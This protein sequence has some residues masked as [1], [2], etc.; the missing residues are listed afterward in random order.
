MIRAITNRSLLALTGLAA[1]TAGLWLIAA[2]YNSSLLPT[3][4]A[5]YTAASDTGHLVGPATRRHLLS[6][7]HG[8]S[9]PAALLALLVLALLWLVWQ[10]GGLATRE[11]RLRAAQVDARAL[12][13]QVAAD[14]ETVDGVAAARARFVADGPPRLHLALRTAPGAEPAHVLDELRHHLLPR[15]AAVCTGTPPRVEVR[16]NGIRA[17]RRE[18]SR[19]R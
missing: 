12:A 15:I 11:L 18:I 4:A 14:A 8:W 2:H 7:V 10:R 16:F 3:G 13:R 19:V 9:L 17:R 6:A 1:I 5:R